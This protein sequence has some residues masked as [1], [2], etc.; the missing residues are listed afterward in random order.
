MSVLVAYTTD[1]YIPQGTDRDIRMEI[2]TEEGNAFNLTGHKVYMVLSSMRTGLAPVIQ[3]E[4]ET[5]VAA[6]GTVIFKFTPEDTEDL[7]TIA[8]SAD[9]L[10][11][12]TSTGYKWPAWSGRIGIT[13]LIPLEEVEA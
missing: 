11:V 1:T 10:V 2:L 12:E 5:V 13:S 6:N 3:K 9:V 8:Y 7:L 4:A